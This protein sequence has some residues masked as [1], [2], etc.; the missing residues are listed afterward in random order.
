MIVDSE[1][2]VKDVDEPLAHLEI[3]DNWKM[4]TGISDE[5]VFLMTTSMETW[6]VADRTAL[7][8]HFK[9]E[10]KEKSLISL[11]ELEN[12]ERKD[13]LGSLEN[14]TRTCKTPYAKGKQSYDLLGE[15]D[16]EILK[17]HLHAFARMVRILS[18][19]LK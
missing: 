4:P 1:E 12:R 11:L 17:M 7:K 18:A 16:A 5:Q 9:N 14:A 13:V 8:K 19:K 10:L 2:P 6:I 15:L 3:R